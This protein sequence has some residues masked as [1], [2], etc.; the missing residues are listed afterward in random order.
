MLK[1]RVLLVFVILVFF[2]GCS[3]KDSA[4]YNK[5]A[6]YWYKEMLKA[7]KNEDL[8]IAGDMFASLQSEHRNS[9]LLKE[10]ILI[11]AKAH[12]TQKEYLLANFYL[13]EFI[14]RFGDKSNMDLIKQLKIRANFLSLRYQNR[15]Q[16]LIQDSIDDAHRFLDEHKNSK[17]RIYVDSMLLRLY[18]AEYNLNHQVALLYKR[19]GK[20]K[21]SSLYKEKSRYNWLEEIEQIEPKERFYREIFNW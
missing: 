19:V 14:K 12:I 3:Q 20:E 17:Y 18:L 7:I 11:L 15:D 13:D 16:I 2:S 5:P 9:P 6:I 8:E 1:V 21:A 4:I 10:A